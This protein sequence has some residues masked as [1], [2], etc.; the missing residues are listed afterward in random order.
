MRHSQFCICISELTKEISAA[1][2]IKVHRKRISADMVLAARFSTGL[3]PHLALP[4]Q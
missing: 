1:Y 3:A 2:L 4:D